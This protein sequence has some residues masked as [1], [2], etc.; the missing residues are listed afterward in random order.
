MAAGLVPDV[1]GLP[2]ALEAGGQSAR[3]DDLAHPLDMNPRWFRPGHTAYSMA[4]FAMS[5]CVLGMSAEFAAEGVAFNA[6]WPRHRH[7]HGG[8]SSFAL[9]GR[10]GDAGRCRKPEIMADAAHAV[11]RKGRPRTSPAIS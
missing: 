3:A 5:L 1:E 8:Q 11:L 7:R 10:R 4:K 6:L 9:S 2:A